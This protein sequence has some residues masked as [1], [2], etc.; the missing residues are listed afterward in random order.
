MRNRYI[1]TIYFLADLT[2]D[3]MTFNLQVNSIKNIN[4]ALDVSFLLLLRLAMAIS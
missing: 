2:R 3:N 4:S 1:S